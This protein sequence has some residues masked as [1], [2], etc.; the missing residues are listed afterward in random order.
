VQPYA[1]HVSTQLSSTAD[2]DRT[3]DTVSFVEHT[4]RTATIAKFLRPTEPSGRHF[5]DIPSLLGHDNKSV[6]R[7]TTRSPARLGG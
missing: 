6:H 5:L 7:A 1:A 2:R 3:P 4:A